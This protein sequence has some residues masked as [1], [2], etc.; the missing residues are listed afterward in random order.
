MIG[1]G[2]EELLR[3]APN[4][5]GPSCRRASLPEN[6]DAKGLDTITLLVQPAKHD[7]LDKR[8]KPGQRLEPGQHS[9]RAGWPVQHDPKHRCWRRRRQALL[10]PLLEAASD[11]PW[12]Q[13]RN[14]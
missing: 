4:A 2:G 6:P 13:P 14:L 8:L 12:G 1:E 5:D 11:R 9:L 10:K 7:W 3:E